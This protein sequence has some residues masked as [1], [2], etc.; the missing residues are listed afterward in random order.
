MRVGEPK[1]ESSTKTWRT[2]SK[3]G[4]GGSLLLTMSILWIFSEK[5][6][7]P[8]ST[9]SQSQTCNG[10]TWLISERKTNESVGKVAQQTTTPFAW[11]CTV[12]SATTA[13][14]EESAVHHG[15]S[16]EPTFL[17]RFWEFV[18]LR[19]SESMAQWTAE[20]LGL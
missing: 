2:C 13:G 3:V 12:K 18:P 11:A 5:K 8:S 19:A 16:A 14:F 17:K 6:G 1:K 20:A 10:T 15:F 4:K 9:K 7:I